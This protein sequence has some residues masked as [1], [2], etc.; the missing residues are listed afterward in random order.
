MNSNINSFTHHLI[1]TDRV[2]NGLVHFSSS[3][4]FNNLHLIIVVLFFEPLES[5]AFGPDSVAHLTFAVVVDAN[6]VL[7]SI[8]PEAPECSFVGPDEEAVALLLI[9]DVVA[10]VVASVV[11]RILALAM[12]LVLFPLAIVLAAISPGVTAGPLYFVVH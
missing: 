9:V 12:H 2:N 4:F 11:P 1:S 7:L 8:F 6:A 3:S 10:G 5:P